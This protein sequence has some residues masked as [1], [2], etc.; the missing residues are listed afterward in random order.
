MPEMAREEAPWDVT[1]SRRRYAADVLVCCECTSDV[2]RN[3]ARGRQIVSK[4]SSG[5]QRMRSVV[6]SGLP[7]W[8]SR[9][10]HI[11]LPGLTIS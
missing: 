7:C 11:P 9:L 2:S 3:P 4:R 8:L 10:V 6:H 1:E 5:V